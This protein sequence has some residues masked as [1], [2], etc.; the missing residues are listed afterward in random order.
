MNLL[1]CIKVGAGIIL[2]VKTEVL[3]ECNYKNPSSYWRIW[4]YTM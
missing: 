3:Q 2:S 1:Q 4:T